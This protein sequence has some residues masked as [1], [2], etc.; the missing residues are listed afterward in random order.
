MPGVKCKRKAG[1]GQD[2][3]SVCHKDTDFTNDKPANSAATSSEKQEEMGRMWSSGTVCG[4]HW[5]KSRWD[6]VTAYSQER[7]NDG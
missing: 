3:A 6:L 5:Q 7:T 2:G 1:A 4:P